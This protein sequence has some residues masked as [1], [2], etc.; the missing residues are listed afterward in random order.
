MAAR[1]ARPKNAV[2]WATRPWAVLWDRT[3][4]PGSLEIGV[5]CDLPGS[6]LGAERAR[7]RCR[8]AGGTGG[9]SSRSRC[10]AWAGSLLGGGRGQTAS[11]HIRSGGRH[12][13]GDGA[14]ATGTRG[15]RGRTTPS[16]GRRSVGEADVRVSSTEAWPGVTVIL[17]PHIRGSPRRR[18]GRESAGH[19]GWCP[20]PAPPR[21]R[22]A[23]PLPPCHPSPRGWGRS[24]S[25]P[26]QKKSC[27]FVA[28]LVPC[29]PCRESAT[30]N[31]CC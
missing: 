22:D 21:R 27:T 23:R 14:G 7:R 18:A 15:D 4:G 8:R 16:I 13:Q 3:A 17:G 26:S 29:A 19:G 1:A 9:R 31:R 2:R 20:G 28:A 5:R 11:V 30:T 10:G 24:T 6:A 25:V 12:S